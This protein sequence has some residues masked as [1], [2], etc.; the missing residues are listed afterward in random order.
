MLFYMLHLLTGEWDAYYHGYFSAKLPYWIHTLWNLDL[1]RA[2]NKKHSRADL[3]NQLRLSNSFND[4]LDDITLSDL[5]PRPRPAKLRRAQSD[6]A[7]FSKSFQKLGEDEPALRLSGC[8][9][10][11]KDRDNQQH[12]EEEATEMRAA[13]RRSIFTMV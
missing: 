6:S 13:E 12:E 3:E 9:N 1:L 11:V 10:D 2:Y 5:P 4:N 8:Q 7:F